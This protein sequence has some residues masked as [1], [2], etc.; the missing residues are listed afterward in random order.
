MGVAL[1]ILALCAAAFTIDYVLPT[2]QLFYITSEFFHAHDAFWAVALA[3]FLI[4]LA[5]LPL[6]A[7]PF[8]SLKGRSPLA[9]RIALIALA[10]L[11]VMLG[12][13]GARRVLLDYPLS[14]DESLARFDSLIFRSGR[15]VA[16]LAEEW[17]RY[18]NALAWQS[19]MQPVADHAALVSA[20]LPVNAGLR[21]LIGF[22][23]DERLTSPLLAALATLSAYGVG[24]RLWPDRRDAAFVSAVLVLTSSQV[25]VTAMTPYAMT[26]HLAFNLLW[27]WLFLHDARI[28]HAV[29]ERNRS[30]AEN[31]VDF[32]I[33]ERASRERPVP[34][35]FM[36]PALSHAGAILVGFLA[37]G[38]HQLVFHPLFA[39]PF[40]FSL[41]R[42]KRIALALVYTLSY[43][44]IGLFWISYWKI[45]LALQNL[46]A[47]GALPG[48]GAIAGTRF[49]LERIASLLIDYEWQSIPLMLKNSLR[50][51]VWQNPL[52]LPLAALSGRAVAHAA[53]ERVRSNA[54]D[55]IDFGE[56][57][58]AS[59]EK[60][61][62]TFSAS[63]ALAQD[64]SYA[65]ELLAG[66]L[67]TF[68]VMCLLMP[69][70]GHGWGY[71]YLHGLIGNLALLAGCGW[72]A[73]TSGGAAREG[74]ATRAALFLSSAF[75]LLVL[76]PAHLKSARALTEPY[77]RADAA[78]RHAKT[79]IVLIDKTGM[80]YGSDFARNDPFMRERP[81][82]LAL[83]KLSDAD[84]A[85][86][87]ARYS[88]E[89]FDA[90]SGA[91]FGVPLN[92]EELVSRDPRR[93]PTCATSFDVPAGDK[94]R[95]RG[96]LTCPRATFTHTP[97]G[98]P[99]PRADTHSK[100]P[101]QLPQT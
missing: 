4:G 45:G 9:Q 59:S 50:F 65:R 75:S 24:R 69:Y 44:G 68:A 67:L 28:D 96:R 2:P 48:A 3:L 43:A 101:P 55:V 51:I 88:M 94:C 30:N 34:A 53:F 5:V 10:L 7:G 35:F 95:A 84:L 15:T 39:A 27:L 89:V 79:D 23:T 47:P 82:R 38:L 12:A 46:A 78:L 85:A 60:P 86:L 18:A 73:A 21:A 37:S 83:D 74:A 41:Y 71:R 49:F 80:R 62:S 72:I 66:V 11:I 70:Q 36:S 16:P 63:R 40:V 64:R 20:Y 6:P 17:R 29:F 32:N 26:A 90:S 31:V 25:L 61:A 91:A 56:S 92:E 100:W 76:L 1:L 77:A 33:L 97:K 14:W 54:H 81:I 57:E 52:L 19:F 42:Q 13:L 58:R 98:G 87:C 22:W 93:W 8:E 99:A